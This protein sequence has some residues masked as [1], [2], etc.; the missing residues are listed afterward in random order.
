M[1]QY[2]VTQEM[3]TLKMVLIGS[4]FMGLQLNLIEIEN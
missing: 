2:P 4:L 1:L 3:K